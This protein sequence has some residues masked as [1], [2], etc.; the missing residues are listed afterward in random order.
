M[1]IVG[2]CSFRNFRLIVKRLILTIENSLHFLLRSIP[3]PKKISKYFKQT[4]D[5]KT[6]YH[7]FDNEYQS[8]SQYLNL[9]TNK[10]TQTSLI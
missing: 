3:I 8:R 2:I 7:Y 6:F 9:F 10:Q 1:L 4:V 5:N